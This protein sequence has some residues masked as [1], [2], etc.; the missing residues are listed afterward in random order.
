MSSGDQN[1]G[2]VADKALQLVLEMKRNPDVLPPYNTELVRQCY[3]KIDELFQKNAA[4]VE[5]IRAGLPHDSTLLQPR[6]AAMCHIRRCMMAYVNE[7]KNRIRSF[8][9]KY[10]G[11]L[12]ASVRN[13]LCDAEI[14]FFNEYSSTLARFQS[15]LGE[16]GVNLLLH[17]APPKSLF[18]QVRALEDYGEFE[19]SD[20]TQVQLSKDSLHSLPRQDCEMLIRQGVLELVH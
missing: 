2:G 16:G 20:G 3:Q 1:R 6:L 13:A 11:A 10:G 17:S 9:W 19:T 14:Q 18:V 7:R 15:N 12:P 8:R 5:K 4:V